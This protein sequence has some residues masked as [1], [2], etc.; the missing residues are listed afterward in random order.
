MR[1]LRTVH[2]LLEE[3]GSLAMLQ[4]PHM[5]TATAEIVA[6]DRPRHEVQRDIKSKERARSQLARKWVLQPCSALCAPAEFLR[7]PCIS[8][9]MNRP[10]EKISHESTQHA[11]LLASAF[12]VLPRS[13]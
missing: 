6:G 11:R 8:K 9:D 10:I 5:A 2:R 12:F 13:Q 7:S 3:G 4:D 1:P